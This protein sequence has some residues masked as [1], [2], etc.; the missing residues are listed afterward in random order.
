MLGVLLFRPWRRRSFRDRLSAL[1]LPL[2]LAA[3]VTG[4]ACASKSSPQTER[5]S[6]PSRIVI[7]S[8]TPN[9]TT[10][11]NVTLRVRIIGGQVVERT[12]GELTPTDG[13]VHVLLD[14]KLIVMSYGTTEELKDLPP[15]S[16]TVE[17]EFVA[18]DHAPFKNRPKAVVIFTVAT[19]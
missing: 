3:V 10:V 4:G 14:G 15:G 9:E 19:P 17:A 5:P 16:H 2:V 7:E 18:V 13:H 6:T 8:P 1:A 12:T 11:A